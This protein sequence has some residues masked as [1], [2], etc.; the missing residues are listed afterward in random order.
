MTIPPPDITLIENCL[1]RRDL[2]FDKLKFTVSWDERMKARK[3][4]SYGVS[5]NYSGMHYP[6]TT[7]LSELLPLCQVI[8]NKF[9]FYPNNCLLNYYQNGRSS[10]GYHSDISEE[11]KSKTG[12]V[13]F[14]LGSTRMISYRSKKDKTV[15]YQYPLNSG[16]LLY[17]TEEIQQEWMHAIPKTI[18]VGER[19][20]LTF[21]SMIK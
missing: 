19:I 5:Y 11:L 9:R 1:D 2:L 8:E 17:M 21:R 15:K 20:S 12:V 16:S 18:D 7:M 3:T 13:I 10:M 6:Q 14:S 4:A